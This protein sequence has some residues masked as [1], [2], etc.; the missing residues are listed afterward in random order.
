MNRGAWNGC[1][2]I[3]YFVVGPPSP[4]RCRWWWLRP[5]CIR[6]IWTNARFH[7]WFESL[8]IPSSTCVLGLYCFHMP[9]I[10]LLAHENHLTPPDFRAKKLVSPIYRPYALDWFSHPIS[11]FLPPVPFSFPLYFLCFLFL[12][13]HLCYKNL[14]LKRIW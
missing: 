6:W 8:L 2:G 11:W 12:L 5:E 1:D 9:N 10:F 14:N 13:M 4:M 3:W 7:F